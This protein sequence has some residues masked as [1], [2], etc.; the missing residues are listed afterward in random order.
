MS[1]DARLAEAVQAI[2]DRNWDA[3]AGFI[4]DGFF[5]HSPAPGEPTA[6]E[7]FTEILSGLTAAMPDLSVSVDDLRRDGEVFTGTLTLVGTHENALWG[8]P[9]TGRRVTWINPI[10]IKPIGDAYALRFDDLAFPE[11]VSAIRQF[12]L[13][14]PPDAMDEPVPHP[15]SIPDFLLKLIFTGQ[16]ADKSCSHL[17]QIR[18]TDPSTRVC[19]ACFDEGVNWPAL[20]MCL[21]C[22]F[23]GCCDTSK[24]KHMIQHHEE[25][26]HALMRSI[27]M[28]EGWVWCYE[29]NAFFERS[30]LDRYRQ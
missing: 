29:D 23:V 6:A 1:V 18:V 9:G 21:V 19:R 22:G 26:G 24:R 27:R 30:I 2:G 13:V 20:R 15:V 25:S 16:A 7:R 8:A 10:T 17:H 4:A 3:L 11:L 28:D 12:G 5:S 14:N